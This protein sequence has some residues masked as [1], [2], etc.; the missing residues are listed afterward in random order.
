MF[1]NSYSGLSE[2]NLLIENVDLPNSFI[3]I[4]PFK[5]SFTIAFIKTYLEASTFYTK[6]FLIK[7]VLGSVSKVLKS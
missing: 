7:T 2:N 4:E 3:W 1:I 5:N 6:Q